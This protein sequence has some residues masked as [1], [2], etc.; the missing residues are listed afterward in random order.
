MLTKYIEIKWNTEAKKSFSEVKLDLT[1]SPILISPN[2]KK[3]FMIFFFC[4]WPHY[5][6]C[7]IVE[8]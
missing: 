7:F 4:I 2:F 6:S 5:C 8:K 1:T 3:A